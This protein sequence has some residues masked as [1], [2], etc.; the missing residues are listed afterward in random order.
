MVADSIARDM[1]IGGGMVALGE[2]DIG[3]R[4]SEVLRGKNIR[5]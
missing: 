2:R 1:G 3:G 5:K 4:V